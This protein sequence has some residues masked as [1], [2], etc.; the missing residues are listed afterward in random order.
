[1]E[2]GRTSKYVY[3]NY[4]RDIALLHGILHITKGE[5]KHRAYINFSL[6]Q[7]RKR[8]KKNAQIQPCIRPDSGIHACD[9]EQHRPANEP[10][11]QEDANHHTQVSKEKVRVKSI[12]LD[13]FAIIGF[14]ECDWP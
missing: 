5:S 7:K 3:K 4:V 13:D 9:G 14:V 1:M 2:R 8:E 10:D 11:G 6:T 12:I